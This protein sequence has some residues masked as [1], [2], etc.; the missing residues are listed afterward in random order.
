MRGD[1]KDAIAAGLLV[2]ATT[3]FSCAAQQNLPAPREIRESTSAAAA[4]QPMLQ[5]TAS[6]T[7]A[8]E[9][10]QQIG[11][12]AEP[13]CSNGRLTLRDRFRAWKLRRHEALH[14]DPDEYNELPLGAA[15]HEA[16]DKQRANAD[17]ALMVLHHQDFG[18][19]R[20]QGR[21]NAR[22][23]EELKKIAQ[24]LPSTFAPVIVEQS[25]DAQLDV[26]R[27]QTVVAELNNGL[28]PVPDERVIIA[29]SVA[30]GLNGVE[31]GIIGVNVFSQTGSRGLGIGGAGLSTGTSSNRP[32][33]P[34]VR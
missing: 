21:L 29:P 14:G 25:G 15:I 27:R 12:K 32:A 11:S 10:N 1:N 9:A 7:Q 18:S 34:P 3:T 17:A 23:R 31:A 4:E 20:D 13:C 30:Y 6:A 28:F 19:G 8:G 2:V 24:M 5:Q 33:G 22:G 26:R 16:I